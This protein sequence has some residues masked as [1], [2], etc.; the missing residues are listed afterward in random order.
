MT[1]LD[2]AV[3]VTSAPSRAVL[4]VLLL[5]AAVTSLN[6]S[7]T[8]VAAP[9]IAQALSATSTEIGWIVDGYTIAFAAVVLLGGAI[10]DRYGRS[11]AFVAGALLLVPAAMLAAWAAGTCRTTSAGASSSSTSTGSPMPKP[12]RSWGSR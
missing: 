5:G 11:R 3:E 4:P 8:N 6:I 1:T 9:S 2:A 12:P 7:V 10:G